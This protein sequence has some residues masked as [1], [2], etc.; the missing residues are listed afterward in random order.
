MKLVW[1][2][3]NGVSGGVAKRIIEYDNLHVTVI[4]IPENVAVPLVNCCNHVLLRVSVGT[5]P[6]GPVLNSLKVG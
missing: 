3:L 1:P 2:E 5:S 6:D 4:L